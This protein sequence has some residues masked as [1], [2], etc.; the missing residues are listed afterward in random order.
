[1]MWVAVEHRD[2]LK[3]FGFLYIEAL[4]YVIGM[5]FKNLFKCNIKDLPMRITAKGNENLRLIEGRQVL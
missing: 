4:L 5:S 1:M 3:S 2:R